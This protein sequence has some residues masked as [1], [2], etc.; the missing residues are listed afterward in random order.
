M[1]DPAAARFIADPKA[2]RFLEPFLGRERTASAVA[3][4]LGVRVSS[5]LYRVRQ[6]LD[7]G[8]LRVA[9]VEPRRGR[10]LKHYRAVAESLFVPF[11]LT[12]AETLQA[13]G[14]G[15]AGEMERALGASLGAGYEAVG[16]AFEGWG[17]RLERDREGRID[18]SLAPASGEADAST[19]Q[20]LA[21]EPGAPALWDQH[22]VLTLT[23]GE[24]KALQRDLSEVFG[25]YYRRGEEQVDEAEQAYI[26][27]LA[28]VSL[29][30]LE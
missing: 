7:L 27:R 8:L 10:A 18:R 21:L 29:K 16:R 13:L 20:E 30:S 1:R 15:S 9:R 12:D 14:L 6:L 4:E 26:I 28:M 11:E 24:A 23:K 19:L 17:V 2:S 25:R 3:A 5:M 22:C